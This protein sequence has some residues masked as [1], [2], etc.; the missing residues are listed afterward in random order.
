[1]KFHST[2]YA[3]VGVLT[4]ATALPAAAT[5][6]GYKYPNLSTVKSVNQTHFKH[7]KVGG[8][9]RHFRP[10][11]KASAIKNRDVLETRN[12][13]PASSQFTFGDND[14]GGPGLVVTNG[15]NQWRGFYIY[16]NSCDSVPLKHFWINAGDTRFIS[17]PAGFQGRVTRGTDAM[18]LDGQPHLLGTWLELSF[19]P[20]NPNLLWGDVSLIQDCDGGILMW[21]LDGSGSWKGFTKDVLADASAGAWAMKSD[22]TWVLGPG[23]GPTANPVTTQYLLNTV[24]ADAVYVNDAHGNPVITTSNGRYGVWMDGGR[25]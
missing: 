7:F 16:E 17:L 25:V 1:M 5:T 23:E 12:S 14:N 3:I 11:F 15:D 13:C 8:L 10:P 6:S 21:S 9:V 22:G 2:L 24:G 19:D 20:S 18:N 4:V